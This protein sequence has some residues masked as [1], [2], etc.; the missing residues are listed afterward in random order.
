MEFEV[1]GVLWFSKAF[2]LRGFI[3]FIKLAGFIGCTGF[4]PQNPNPSHHSPP[5][6]PPLAC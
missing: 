1:Y 6:P 5:P 4:R 3:G 2:G